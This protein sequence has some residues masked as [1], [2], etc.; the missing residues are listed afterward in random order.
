MPKKSYG[1]KVTGERI[2]L[3][4][5]LYKTSTQVLIRDLVDSEGQPAGTEVV[6]E[7]RI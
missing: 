7:I 1:M 5:Q 2:A 4:N 3:I 6:L